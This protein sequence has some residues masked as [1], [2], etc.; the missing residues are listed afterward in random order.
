MSDLLNKILEANGMSNEKAKEDILK[1]KEDEKEAY[2]REM[3]GA[4]TRLVVNDA[5]RD[6]KARQAQMN[7]I[8]GENEQ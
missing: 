8:K 5:I 4:V 1:R 2:L 3:A 6:M 7:D